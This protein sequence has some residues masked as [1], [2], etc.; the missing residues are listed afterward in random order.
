MHPASTPVLQHT[1]NDL[2]FNKLLKSAAVKLVTKAIQKETEKNNTYE[3]K[4]MSLMLLCTPTFIGLN[5]PPVLQVDPGM[6][7]MGCR[8]PPKVK[9]SW[10]RKALCLGH[11]SQ[12]SFKSLTFGPSFEWKRTSFSPTRSSAR[13]PQ[14][15]WTSAPYPPYWLVLYARHGPTPLANSGSATSLYNDDIKQNRRRQNICSL[16]LLHSVS[17]SPFLPCTTMYHFYLLTASYLPNLI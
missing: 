7:G 3:R 1:G 6:D 2:T 10:L 4:T 15:S 13:G 12:L 9:L 17:L 16:L 14:Y 8:P 11:K 5:V